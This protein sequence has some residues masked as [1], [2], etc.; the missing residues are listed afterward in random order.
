M[1]PI[2]YD[3]LIDNKIKLLSMEEKKEV[4]DFV[5]FVSLK[6]IKQEDVLLSALKE[7]QSIGRKLGVSRKDIEAEI[8]QVRKKR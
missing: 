1:N 4:Y 8:K 7:G 5:E 2:K 6:K 3:E